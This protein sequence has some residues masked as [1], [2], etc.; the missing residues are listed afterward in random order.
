MGK[1]EVVAEE[2]DGGVAVAVIVNINSCQC[3]GFGGV[4]GTY[5]E[6]MVSSERIGSIIILGKRIE[7]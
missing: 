3:F 6:G 2:E 4:R 7:L 1:A 5:Q